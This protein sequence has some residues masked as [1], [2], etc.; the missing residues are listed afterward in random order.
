MIRGNG[1][2]A[3]DIG[4]AGTDMILPSCSA[5]QARCNYVAP[6]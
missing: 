4:R 6:Y 3:L 1:T 2:L 5:V